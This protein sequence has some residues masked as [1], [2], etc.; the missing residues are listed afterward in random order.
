MNRWHLYA[1]LIAVV[2][3]LCAGIGI[4]LLFR[5][6]GASLIGLALWTVALVLLPPGPSVLL[7]ALDRADE[8]WRR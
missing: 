2:G 7:W 1:A 6:G 5:P 3:I 4:S 8:R